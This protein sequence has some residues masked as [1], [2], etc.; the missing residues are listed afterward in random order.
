M[1][2]TAFECNES[3]LSG[4]STGSEKSPK[5]VA[6]GAA[7]TDLTDL[8]FMGTIVS[9]GEA[10]AVVYATG[11]DAPVRPDARGFPVNGNRKRTSRSVCAS[12]PTCC[13]A[14]RSC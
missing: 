9:A 6:A 13:C 5:P 14:W 7:L 12:S 11:E 1:E 3:I 8:A 4:E 10:V 2:A